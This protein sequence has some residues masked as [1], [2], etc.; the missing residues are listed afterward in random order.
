MIHLISRS[1]QAFKPEEGGSKLKAK[2]TLLVARPFTL[3]E[4]LRT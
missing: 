1:P 3:E 2:F 4:D